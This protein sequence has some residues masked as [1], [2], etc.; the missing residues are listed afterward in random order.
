M[1]TIKNFSHNYIKDLRWINKYSKHCVFKHVYN[2]LESKN[3]LPSLPS[4]LLV[5]QLWN[6]I[7]QSSFLHKAI[8]KS[9]LITFLHL[10]QNIYKY[11]EGCQFSSTKI[12]R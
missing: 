10:G 12:K 9:E 8:L 4:A 1:I 2:F 11:L 5:Q 3:T 6:D 7:Q